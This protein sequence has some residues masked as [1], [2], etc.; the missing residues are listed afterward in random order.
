[1]VP[2]IRKGIC[3]FIIELLLSIHSAYNIDNI[4]I[5]KYTLNLGLITKGKG[6]WRLMKDTCPLV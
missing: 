6:S 3:R 2:P 5:I 1:M 4:I